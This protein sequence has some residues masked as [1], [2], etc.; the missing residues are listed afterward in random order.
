MLRDG[1][2]PAFGD[3]GSIESLIAGAR[4]AFTYGE[5]EARELR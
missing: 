2:A 5:W 3:N 4:P 1:A